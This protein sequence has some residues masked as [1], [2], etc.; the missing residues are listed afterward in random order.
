MELI[1][2]LQHYPKDFPEKMI[3]FFASRKGSITIDLEKQD[4]INFCEQKKI[5]VK[6]YVNKYFVVY[7]GIE[8]KYEN[9]FSMKN[10]SISEAINKIKKVNEILKKYNIEYE[11]IFIFDN[12]TIV[13]IEEN[14]IQK[15]EDIEK[16]EK[17]ATK[18]FFKK[19]GNITFEAEI[20][21]IK[22]ID[23]LEVL[24]NERY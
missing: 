1:N 13:T 22:E 16:D 20:K 7:N 14:E 3:S 21:E 2:F 5:K 10:F 18:Y 23:Y 9:S 6:K 15:F 19:I 11:F 8:F 24:K 12:E 4:F 17:F